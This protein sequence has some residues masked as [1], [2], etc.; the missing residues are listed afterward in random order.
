MRRSTEG[1]GR[2]R[3]IRPAGTV[4]RRGT[5]VG[6]ALALAAVATLPLTPWAQA[7]RSAAG[8][9][10]FDVG[11]RT[12]EFEFRAAPPQHRGHKQRMQNWCWAACI[13]MI[14]NYHGVAA[15]Q[16]Q[17]V[18]RT[19]GALADAPGQ[20][21]QILGNLNGWGLRVDGLP[22]QVSAN[23]WVLSAGQLVYDLTIDQPL[24]LGLSMPGMMGHAYVLTAIRYRE[25]GGEPLVLAAVLRDPM[26]G[27]PDRI[28]M[29]WPRI[30]ALNPFFARVRVRPVAAGPPHTA[31][32][33]LLADAPNGG[34]LV[35]SVVAG[36]AAAQAGLGP[37]DVIYGV[38]RVP[39]L[40]GTDLLALLAH[41]RPG[42]PVVIRYLRGGLTLHGRGVLGARPR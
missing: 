31:L 8:P 39:I 28:V 13:Q 37:N 22:L 29:P 27:N 33:A 23:S 32:G 19:F 1:P 4:L 35:Q 40:V 26:P 17:I 12:A 7:E 21:H 11:V 30:M 2:R 34:L 36:S 3:A 14:L 20:P 9:G 10:V 24:L 42:S 16:E 6:T 5:V 38:D 25:T 18:G 41:K 15:T